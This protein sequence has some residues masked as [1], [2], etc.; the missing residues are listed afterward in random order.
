MQKIMSGNFNLDSNLSAASRQRNTV[1]D[2]SVRLPFTRQPFCMLEASGSTSNPACL[3]A[4]LNGLCRNTYKSNKS[5]RKIVTKWKCFMHH[6]G[7]CL[8]VGCPLW[9]RLRGSDRCGKVRKHSGWRE[10]A[11]CLYST[12]FRETMFENSACE[13]VSVCFKLFRRF[14]LNP[15][16]HSTES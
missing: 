5:K 12:S 2:V 15:S 16:R 9:G 7:S 1:N 14:S 10:V 8:S 11:G 3:V 6:A 4:D 13:I